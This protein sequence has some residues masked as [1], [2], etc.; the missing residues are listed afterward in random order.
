MKI[1]NKVVNVALPIPLKQ[2]FQYINCSEQSD[3]IGYS[4]S[5]PFGKRVLKG[6]VI[7]EVNTPITKNLKT[8][9]EVIGSLPYY[10]QKEID[11]FF[12]IAKYY[13]Y[14]LGQLISKILP[15]QVDNQIPII[16]EY[17]LNRDSEK[18]NSHGCG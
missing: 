12:L 11:F 14:P 13:H 15:I 16:N 5:V 1:K 10:S 9:L 8:I 4:V 17:S 7:S 6:I 2:C 18:P 3:I